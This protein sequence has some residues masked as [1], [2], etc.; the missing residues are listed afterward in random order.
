MTWLEFSSYAIHSAL[1]LRLGLESVAKQVYASL[2]NSHSLRTLIKM[3]FL[4]HFT[5]SGSWSS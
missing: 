4:F 2:N 1:T 5:K 3:L